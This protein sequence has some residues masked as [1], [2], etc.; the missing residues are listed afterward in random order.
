MDEQ[1]ELYYDTPIFGELITI[2]KTGIV[3]VSQISIDPRHNQLI[4]GDYLI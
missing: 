1:V 4:H 2:T 3:S